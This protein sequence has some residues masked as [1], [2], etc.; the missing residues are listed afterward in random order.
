M[1][2]STQS[3]AALRR[4]AEAIVRVRRQIAEYGLTLGQLEAAGCWSKE[5]QEPAGPVRYRDALGQTWDGRG[6]MPMWLQRAVNAGQ[7]AEHF[8]VEG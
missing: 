5:R 2:E 3:G 1:T 4:R 8:A 7:S 6:E